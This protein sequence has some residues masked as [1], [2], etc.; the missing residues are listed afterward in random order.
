MNGSFAIKSLLASNANVDLDDS[1]NT[2]EALR[3]LGYYKTP[4]YGMTPY[5]DRELFGGI[6]ALQKA[7]GIQRTGEMRPGDI[8][9]TVIRQALNEN[10]RKA[11][12]EQKDGTYIWRTRGDSKVRSEH[13]DRDGKIFSWDEPP[14]GGHPGEAPN[15]RCKAE[16][17][18]DMNAMCEALFRA[19]ENARLETNDKR[20]AYLRAQADQ[21]EW[22]TIF[23]ARQQEFIETLLSFGISETLKSKRQLRSRLE[24][25]LPIARVVKAFKQIMDAWD[26]MDEADRQRTAHKSGKEWLLADWQ[27]AQKEYGRQSDLYREKCS[28]NEN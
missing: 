3:H 5:P 8:T 13:A 12:D 18:S 4:R 9:E 15:C 27:S 19:V 16:A 10:T 28:E 6:S 24:K 21:V 14:E 11:A 23:V 7:Q 22:E 26:A 17:M 2:K 25:V 1:L 20:S